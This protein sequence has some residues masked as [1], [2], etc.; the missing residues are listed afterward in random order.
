MTIFRICLI[1]VFLML[2]GCVAQLALIAELATV[3]S[4]FMDEQENK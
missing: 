2:S 3:S 4:A 1:P